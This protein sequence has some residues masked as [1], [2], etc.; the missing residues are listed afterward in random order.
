MIIGITGGIGSGKSTIV[1]T[2][3]ARGFATYDCDREAKRLA[4][5]DTEVREAIIVLLGEEAFANG[6][7]NTPYVAKRVFA[8]PVLLER[9]NAI[10]HPA[11]IRDIKEQNILT[12]QPFLFVESAI[13]FEA[14]MDAL[15]DKI[16]VIDA[17]EEIR[18]TRTI[19][20][21]YHGIAS[22]ENIN[23]VRA[24]IAAQKKSPATTEVSQGKIYV[25]INDGQRPINDLV[26]D[27]VNQYCAAS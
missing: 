13:L 17:P 12:N 26:N 7:Y 4:E 8:D 23:K 21:D 27:I 22:Q 9:L 15:C 20:R 11:V 10:I 5:E 18:I 1:R 24:R 16:L 25:I 6:R 3:A 19:N 2:L 14:G